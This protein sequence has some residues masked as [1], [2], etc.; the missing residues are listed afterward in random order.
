MD[1]TLEGDDSELDDEELNDDTPESP[2][3]KRDVKR[4][5]KEDENDKLVGTLQFRSILQDELS[6]VDR[7]RP[8]RQGI[9]RCPTR[10]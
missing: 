8:G 10:G 1:T 2:D 6:F 9:S 4:S 5:M 3:T 7:K